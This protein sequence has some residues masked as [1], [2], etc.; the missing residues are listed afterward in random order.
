MKKILAILLVVVMVFSLTACKSKEQKAADDFLKEFE[1]LVDDFIEAYEDKDFDRV[2]QI[3]KELESMDEEFNQ[4]LEDL[5]ESDE[6]AAKK[7]CDDIE[8]IADK[9]EGLS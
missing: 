7:F 2:S 8:A 6:D 1:T 9:M 3:S 4:V 5:K